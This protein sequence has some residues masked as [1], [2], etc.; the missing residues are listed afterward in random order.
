VEN[1]DTADAAGLI[2]RLNDRP[3]FG[4]SLLAAVQHLLA[5]VVA[6]ATPT[7]VIGQALDLGDRLPFLIS[8]SLMVSGVATFIQSRRIGPVGAGLLSLQGTSFNF[9]PVIIAAGLSVKHAGGG[10]DAVLAMIFGLCLAGSVVEMVLSRFV[11]RLRRIIT[12]TVT[13]TVITAIGLSLVAV[14]FDEVAGDA[15]TANYGN[16]AN[17]ALALFVIAAIVAANF[18]PNRTLRIAAVLAGLAAGCLVAAPLGLLDLGGL[19]GQPLVVVPVPLKFG[20]DF[21]VALFVPIAFLY[22]I[23]SIETVGDLTANSVVSG[24]PVEGPVYLG[25]IRRGLLGDGVN[26]AL[27]AIFNTFPNTTFSQNN[28]IIQLTGIA[29]RHVA[30][31]TG[32]LL[33]LLG[34]VP[35]FAALFTVIPKPVIGGALLVLFGSIAANGIRILS[36]QPFDRKRIFVISISLALGV[37]VALVPDALKQLPDALRNILGS[38]V[39]VTGLTAIILTLAIPEPKPGD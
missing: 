24:E 17:L 16:P 38:S 21:D 31:F 7:L 12:P 20:L 23:T 32:P 5:S 33:V 28:G 36:T 27:A 10:P 25:R 22:M 3:P 30:L 29:S 8:M 4:P 11:D 2:Y 9:V 6:I 37:G 39:T 18:Q 14:A 1:P 15:G 19:A 26:S 13:G 35:V 34:A